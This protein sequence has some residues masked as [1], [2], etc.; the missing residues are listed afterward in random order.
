MDSR[1]WRGTD[2][3]LEWADAGTEHTVHTYANFEGV[4]ILVVD[5]GAEDAHQEAEHSAQR[6]GHSSQGR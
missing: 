1:D 3:L 5:Q 4:L 6:V 2:A